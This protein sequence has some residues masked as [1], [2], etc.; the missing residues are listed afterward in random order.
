MSWVL[1]YDYRSAPLH[2]A[3]TARTYALP[4]IPAAPRIGKNSPYF[5]I[6]RKH[7]C[8]ISVSVAAAEIRYELTLVN[9]CCA[10][11]TVLCCLLFAKMCSTDNSTQC[12]VQTTALFSFLPKKKPP[13]SK[14]MRRAALP[15]RRVELRQIEIRI[16]QGQAPVRSDS[17]AGRCWGGPSG[18]SEFDPRRQGPM[19]AMNVGVASAAGACRL[20]P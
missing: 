16:T 10:C 14:S 13:K 7:R 2:Q 6:T 1:V 9:V 5:W 8:D 4:E 3:T 12:K 15:L 19:T 18:I 11:K 20:K 17:G